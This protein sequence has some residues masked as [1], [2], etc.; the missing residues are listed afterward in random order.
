MAESM[1]RSW[2]RLRD[3]LLSLLQQDKGFIDRISEFDG[4]GRTA[5][6]MRCHNHIDFDSLALRQNRIG[7][8]FDL[9]GTIVG[10][11]CGDAVEINERRNL[12]AS[13]A[14]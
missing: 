14:T 13:R 2:G 9:N 4:C 5:T 11:E 1:L 3:L 7:G 6:Q 12:G 8:Q 10:A